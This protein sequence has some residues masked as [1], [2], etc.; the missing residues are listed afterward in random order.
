MVDRLVRAAMTATSS[1]TPAGNASRLSF[2]SKCEYA[3]LCV[4]ARHTTV[5]RIMSRRYLCGFCPGPTCVNQASRMYYAAKSLEPEG[6]AG[7]VQK[8]E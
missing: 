7:Y 2:M 6:V 4:T 5:E 3:H 8:C 1:T